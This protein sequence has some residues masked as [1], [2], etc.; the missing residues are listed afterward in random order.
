MINILA[1]PFTKQVLR[2]ILR[3]TKG[4]FI[5]FMNILEPDLMNKFPRYNK[6]CSIIPE[7]IFM[8][9]CVE[10]GLTMRQVA[11]R[12]IAHFKIKDQS[13]INLIYTLF[14]AKETSDFPQKR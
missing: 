14:D 5:K 3:M 11:D 7:P 2:V 13:D 9:I 12:F 1:D 8:W 10:Y 6:R 4:T